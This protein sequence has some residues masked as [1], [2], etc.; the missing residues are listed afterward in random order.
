GKVR[1]QP[2]FL[3]ERAAER[4]QAGLISVTRP[5]L[6]KNDLD[7]DRAVEPQIAAE[8]DDAH[9]PP[10]QLLDNPVAV[11]NDPAR[12]K[13]VVQ[14]PVLLGV[15]PRRDPRAVDADRVGK[16]RV[17]LVVSRVR[18]VLTDGR[19]PSS[20]SG[21]VGVRE[22]KSEPIGPSAPE[23]ALIFLRGRPLALFS[24]SSSSTA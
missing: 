20:T 6:Q 13:D 4:R 9:A 23:L 11:L 21:V 3:G 19:A 12:R 2:G 10:A 14:S 18:P 22:P 7:R 8:E 17:R 1:P 24:R 15:N 16:C 5:P